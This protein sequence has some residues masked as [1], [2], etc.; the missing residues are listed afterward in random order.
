[1]RT[2]FISQTKYTH[3]IL[4]K[5]GMGAIK[6]LPSPFG[7]SFELANILRHSLELQTS[8]PQAPLRSKLPRG[9]LSLTLE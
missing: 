1:M 4:K 2:T 3:D 6:G 9:D 5:F 7:H 8:L